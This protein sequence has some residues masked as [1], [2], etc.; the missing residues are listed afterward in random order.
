MTPFSRCFVSSAL[1]PSSHRTIFV[2]EKCSVSKNFV[3]YLFETSLEVLWRFALSNGF[4]A[5]TLLFFFSV[6]V[7]KLFLSDC[8]VSCPILSLSKCLAMNHF[9]WPT[10]FDTIFARNEFKYFQNLKK[11]RCEKPAKLFLWFFFSFS[12]YSFRQGISLSFYRISWWF[13]GKRNTH[14][15]CPQY[16][17]KLKI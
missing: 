4:I 6:R 15:I 11:S 3:S 9:L 17:L 5:H 7:L 8:M 16:V 1:S 12:F 10:K 14:T 13:K 2:P